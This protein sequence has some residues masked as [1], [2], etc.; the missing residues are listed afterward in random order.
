VLDEATRLYETRDMQEAVGHQLLEQDAREFI[1][2]YH[3]VD[4]EVRRRSPGRRVDQGLVGQVSRQTN[5]LISQHRRGEYVPR[6]RM[7]H[8][9]TPY[10]V[11]MH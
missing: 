1:Q 8:R 7:H 6:I 3:E 4:F 5:E 11:A 2:N 9:L 10:L